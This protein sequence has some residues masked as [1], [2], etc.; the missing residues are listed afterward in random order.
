MAPRGVEGDM[1]SKGK[2]VN[3]TRLEL[4]SYFA[5]RNFKLVALT[6]A[7]LSAYDFGHLTLCSAQ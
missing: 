5:R 3:L 6:I 7:R 2:D 1:I 4:D